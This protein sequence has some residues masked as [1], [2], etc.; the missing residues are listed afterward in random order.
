LKAVLFGSLSKVVRGPRSLVRRSFGNLIGDND[1]RLSAVVAFND[2]PD[3][4]YVLTRF[5]AEREVLTLTC[6]GG[7][8]GDAVLAGRRGLGRDK[9]R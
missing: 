5:L 8:E 3:S 4:N 1:W 2:K 6:Q 7:L 9:P